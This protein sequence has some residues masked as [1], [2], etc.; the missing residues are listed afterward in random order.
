MTLDRRL[1]R[2]IAPF[3]AATV[4]GFAVVPIGNRVDWAGYA[5]ASAL[6]LAIACVAVVV[7]RRRLPGALRVIPS[8]LFL[9]AVGLLRNA[10]PDAVTGVGALALVPVFW[11]A[12]HGG[13]GQ[14]LILIAGVCAFFLA[15]AF[16]TDGLQYPLGSWR[17]AVV[18]GAVSAIVGIAV[19]DLVAR[20]RSDAE[21]L[22]IREH[23]LEA[24]VD[25][26]RSLSG[27]PD[28]RDRICAAACELSGAH[29]ALLL[30]GQVDGTLTWAAGAGVRLPH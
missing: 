16:I 19:Q 13:R 9:V 2:E 3:G 21:A 25:L 15:P 28:A 26:S 27:S 17:V 1:V 11:L 30:E 6:A 18:F 10:S 24:M 22:A 14:L 23:D 4:L 29:F 8:L 12:L 7:P 5:L 20:V